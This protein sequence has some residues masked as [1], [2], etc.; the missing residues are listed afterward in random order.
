MAT[1]KHTEDAVNVFDGISYDKGASVINMMGY[2][3]GK[4]VMKRAMRLYLKKHAWKNTV[5]SD[6]IAALEESCKESPD[7]KNFDVRGWVA[8][9][10][11]KSGV[12]VLSLD[13]QSDKNKKISKFAV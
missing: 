10:L 11:D 7:L 2:F 13:L 8:T 6:F 1:V 4:D 9:W 3:F 12:N 5:F